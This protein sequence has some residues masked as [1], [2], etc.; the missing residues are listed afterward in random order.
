MTSEPNKNRAETLM[1]GVMPVQSF[2]SKAIPIVPGMVLEPRLGR[3]N[4]HRSTDQQNQNPPPP[5]NGDSEPK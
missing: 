3:P 2:V 1:V 5:A 4:R